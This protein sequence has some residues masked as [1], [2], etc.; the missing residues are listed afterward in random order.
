V[1]SFEET[2]VDIKLITAIIRR[3]RLEPVEEKLKVVGVKRINVTKAKG[4]GEYRNFFASDW[5][6]DEV[7]LDIFTREQEVEGIT[8]AIMEAAHTGVRGDGV[9]AVI[10]VDKLFLIRTKAEATSEEFWPKPRE[11][12]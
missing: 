12:T 1:Q 7:K 10:S 2:A 5:M 6:V 8:G 4:Y 9:V 3:D 11:Q